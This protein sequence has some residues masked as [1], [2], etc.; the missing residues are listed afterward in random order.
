MLAESLTFNY[1]RLL[2][3]YI[4][5]VFI[6]SEFEK[7]YS[8]D[9]LYAAHKIARRSKRDVKEVIDFEIELGKNLALLS[10]EIK[11][12]SYNISGYYSFWVYD[13]KAREI[14]ALHYKDRVVQHCICDE[15][16]APMLDKRLIYDNAACRINKGT[17]F[18][19]KRLSSFMASFY[20]KH[21]THGYFLK[22]DI[23][24]F[25]D[26]I[27]HS[28]IKQKL[29]KVCEDQDVLALLYKIIDS[30]E[31][32]NGKGLPLGNQTS[33]W[34]AI[35]YL[36]GF[37]RLIKEK[38]QIKYYTR[39]MDDCILIH[40]DKE[41]LRSCLKTMKCYL[42][43]ELGL[44]LNE[45]TKIFPMKNGVNYLGWHFYIT[46]NGKIV[47]KVKQSTKYKYKRKLKYLQNAYVSGD[48]SYAEIKQIISS[49]NSHLSFGHTY[50][51]R[52]SI[53]KDF[54][55]QKTDD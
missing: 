17:H 1:F 15:V 22:C 14:H 54:V 2:D 41:Y 6:M 4:L 16:L 24:K 37:D 18:A 30:Y 28:V 20:K 40:E 19:I 7:I 3:V 32:T 31:K 47:R 34:F 43:K 12:G 53:F 48:I 26:N 42:E 33:Q 35:Y 44:T 13:P 23:K 51:L 25:F 50:R 45:K 10:E 38:L 52:Q 27:D 39:Y 5:P 8:F 55:L 9:N 21:G 46:E 49:Y 36:D 29:S 11:N